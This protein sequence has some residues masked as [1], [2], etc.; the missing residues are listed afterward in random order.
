MT[1]K[2][3]NDF[4]FGEGDDADAT[5]CSANNG[6][7]GRGVDAQRGYAIEVKAGVV[8]GEFENGC[9]GTG[10]PEDESVVGVG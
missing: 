5:C 10:V 6:E 2:S 1:T 9:R 7:G 8:G 4:T 3:L